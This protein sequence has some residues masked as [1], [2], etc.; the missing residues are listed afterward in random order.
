MKNIIYVIIS[1]V[2]ILVVIQVVMMLFANNYKIVKEAS[3]VNDQTKNVSAEG[4][5]SFGKLEQGKSYTGTEIIEYIR[6]NEKTETK[7][8]IKFDPIN[9]KIIDNSG[10]PGD[11]SGTIDFIKNNYDAV[12]DMSYIELNYKVDQLDKNSVNFLLLS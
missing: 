11:V 1:S 2:A 10:R 12:K 7:I 5:L 3:G 4:T 9:T 6:F 8:Q